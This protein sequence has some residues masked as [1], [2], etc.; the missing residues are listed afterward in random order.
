RSLLRQAQPVFPGSP[1]VGA[2]GGKVTQGPAR[3]DP[4]RGP[5]AFVARTRF[6]ASAAPIRSREEPN[7]SGKSGNFRQARRHSSPLSFGRRSFVLPPGAS[8]GGARRLRRDVGAGVAW[9]Q[10]R[11][12]QLQV[13]GTQ[14]GLSAQSQGL[15]R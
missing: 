11:T 14:R 7:D 1:L 13:A 10:S 8:A 3:F 4:R 6:R 2:G 9:G 12:G 5:Q 15:E